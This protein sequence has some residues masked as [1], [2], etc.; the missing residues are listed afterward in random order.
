MVTSI[1]ELTGMESGKIQIQEL[2]KFVSLGYTG[3]NGKVRGY[4]T[5]CDIAPGFYEELRGTGNLLDMAI[6]S[7]TDPASLELEEVA[8]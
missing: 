7:P 1:T 8:E 4:F 5:G 3:A 2:F 6:F